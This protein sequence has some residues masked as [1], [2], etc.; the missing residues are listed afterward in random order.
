MRFTEVPGHVTIRF[1]VADDD[2]QYKC[3][4]KKI[5]AS[6]MLYSKYNLILLILHP[7]HT[8]HFPLISRKVF[9]TFLKMNKNTAK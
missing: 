7:F 6:R 4:S 9:S 2:V 5:L 8:I 3:Q 1:W